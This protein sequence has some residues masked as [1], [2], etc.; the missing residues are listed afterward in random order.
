MSDKPSIRHG[1]PYGWWRSDTFAGVLFVF[2]FGPVIIGLI[3]AWLFDLAPW[4]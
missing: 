3:M 4:W 2:L 1:L